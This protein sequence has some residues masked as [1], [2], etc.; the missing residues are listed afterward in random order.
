MAGTTEFTYPLADNEVELPHLD[1]PR[2]HPGTKLNR[3]TVVVCD[4]IE[5]IEVSDIKQYG[6]FVP[7][8][9]LYNIMK[10]MKDILG[11][12]SDKA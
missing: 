6:G 12:D 2:S 10:T 8:K 5:S 9:V 3:P 11:T 1:P 4:W 7:N